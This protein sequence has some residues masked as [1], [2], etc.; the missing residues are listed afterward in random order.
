MLQSSL[1]CWQ[2]KSLCIALLLLL[3]GCLHFCLQEAQ[4]TTNHCVRRRRILHHGRHLLFWS[5][6]KRR[7]E[8]NWK[9]YRLFCII[10][11]FSSSHRIQHCSWRLFFIM[12]PTYFLGVVRNH[13]SLGSPNL[14]PHTRSYR[15]ILRM[16]LWYSKKKGV[17][18]CNPQHKK[19][20]VRI[21]FVSPR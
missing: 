1:R 17:N 8:K 20:C 4:S 21:S 14:N 6:Q 19:Y 15:G 5:Y 3:S 10:S 11:V 2:R 18:V 7:Q 16:Y 13:V 12:W 9:I